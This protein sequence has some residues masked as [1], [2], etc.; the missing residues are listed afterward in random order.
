MGG[1]NDTHWDPS[2]IALPHHPDKMPYQC[3][4]CSIPPGRMVN[5]RLFWEVEKVAALQIL[6][7]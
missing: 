5:V 6:G 4:Q 2:I 1:G 7:A 3:K